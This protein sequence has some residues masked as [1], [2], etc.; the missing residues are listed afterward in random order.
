[1]NEADAVIADWAAGFDQRAAEA[2]VLPPHHPQC[3]G[4][5]P[6]NPHGHH[7]QARRDGER[8]VSEHVFDARHVGA[9]GI[10]HGGA[11]ATV[12]DDLFGFVLYLVGEPAVT[13]HLEID[14]H[15]PVL[16]RRRYALEARLERRDG[17]KLFVRASGT[18][19]AGR[20]AFTAQA[21]FIVVPLQHFAGKEA[22]DPPVAP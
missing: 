6:G 17:R 22:G 10:A 13:R 7:L 18:D 5:G 4:C 3:L 12:I 11:V 19:D 9:P 16:L 1:M 21:V 15:A 2:D 14:Y 8:V 20:T